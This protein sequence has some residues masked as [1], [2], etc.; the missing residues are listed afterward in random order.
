MIPSPIG[1]AMDSGLA[2]DAAGLPTL[3]TIDR[4]GQAILVEPPC[5]EILHEL[6][7][8]FHDAGVDPTRGFLIKPKRETLYR[9][10]DT[11]GGQ[12]AMLL[13]G[14]EPLV[15][16][17]LRDAG[18]SVAVV[19]RP[20]AVLPP[21]RPLLTSGTPIDPT[22]IDF[23]SG[24]ERGLIRLG[25]DVEPA[26]LIAQLHQAYPGVTIA[27]TAV[28]H[29]DVR[30]FGQALQV[31]VPAACWSTGD[32]FPADPGPLIVTTLAGLGAHGVDL[33]SRDFLIFLHAR[34]ALGAAADWPLADARRARLFGLARL[35][36]PLAPYDRDRTWA[37]FG[38][39][40]LDIP[41]P[42]RVIR[43]VTAFT[44]RIDGARPAGDLSPADLKRLGL[45][46]YPI[47]N[48]RLARLAAA[49]AG[50]DRAEV[51]RKLPRLAQDL[52]V[53]PLGVLVLVEGFEHAAPLA[54][55]LP[56]WGVVTGPH[57]DSR[58]T[59]A[60]ALA[61]PLG[62]EATAG[63]RVIATW[64]GLSAVDLENVDVLIRADGGVGVPKRLAAGPAT[65]NPDR[66]PLLVVD[67]DDRHHPALR[68]RAHARRTA[69]LSLGWTVDGRGGP[70]APLDLFRA[71]RPR[72]SR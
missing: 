58:S 15:V 39:D 46:Q 62:A 1:R 16:T 70:L 72:E 69:Y 21:P 5:E 56:G 66:G 47:R 42:G 53:S 13:A 25:P 24:R 19:P 3:V 10:W 26:R 14:L 35:S 48:R 36:E 23:V 27:V 17:L 18:R 55:L 50:E 59:L 29:D 6:A 45:W 30:R 2:I 49:L 43:R 61:R 20:L 40:A 41:A 57:I 37:F 33:H 28:R 63:L 64:D 54:G 51:A 32:D 52:P 22:L 31:L 12:E 38:F 71:T 67:C 11:S 68:R 60:S 9:I 7:T 4:D 44:T 65:V 8:T 34:E